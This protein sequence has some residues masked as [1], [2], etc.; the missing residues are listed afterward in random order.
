MRAH[1]QA[2][3]MPAHAWWGRPPHTHTY[4]HLHGWDDEGGLEAH[5]RLVEIL[6][7]YRDG[8]QEPHTE[9]RLK[10]YVHVHAHAGVHALTCSGMVSRSQTQSK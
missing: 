5:E 1:A 2:A 4:A 10:L 6:E 8:K 3:R 9:K 7:L